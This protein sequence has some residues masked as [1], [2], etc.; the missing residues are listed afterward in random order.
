M[1]IVK[2]SMKHCPSCRKLDA[3]LE[4]LDLH[5][6]EVVMDM[7]NITTKYQIFSVPTL[8]KF[9]DD[10]EID[11]ITG[12]VPPTRIKQFFEDEENG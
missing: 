2:F 3:L 8:I 5:C 4:K 10:E 9:K 7:E 1:K 6:D 11:R 12:L